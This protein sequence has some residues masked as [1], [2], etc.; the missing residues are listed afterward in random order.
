[1]VRAVTFQNLTMVPLVPE[2][3]SVWQT[4][5]FWTTPSRCGWVE[6]T[7]ST[8][9]G[10][11]PELKIVNRGNLAVLLLDG[12]ELLGAKQN[13]VRQ[14]DH[15]RS[16]AAF[17]H[18][19]R[20]PASS[21]AGGV[22]LPEGSSLHHAPNLPRA[23]R[24]RCVRSPAHCRR[25]A[26]AGPI[27]RQCG[28]GSRRSRRASVRASDTGA[29]SAMFDKVDHSLDDFVAAFPPVDRQVGAVFAS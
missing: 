12:E 27:S 18:H 23:E 16:A 28:A 6:I 4:T 15:A 21:P 1:M 11:V 14:P 29:M 17:D 7:E 3:V 19:S 13:R 20:F 10:Q 26:L 25:P 8:D 24:Q 2:R 5:W 22:T 9:A